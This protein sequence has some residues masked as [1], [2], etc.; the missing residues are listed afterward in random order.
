MGLISYNL[1]QQ[2]HKFEYKKKKLLEWTCNYFSNKLRYKK[3]LSVYYLNI[4]SRLQVFSVRSQGQNGR[5]TL[6]STNIPCPFVFRSMDH[7][8]ATYTSM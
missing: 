4:R 1:Y 7:V 2:E 5:K 8:N 3:N 6:V